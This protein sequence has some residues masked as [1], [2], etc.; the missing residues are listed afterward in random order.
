MKIAR[1]GLPHRYRFV[2]FFQRFRPLVNPLNPVAERVASH[3]TVRDGD[4]VAREQCVLLVQSLTNQSGKPVVV[5]I[6]QGQLADEMQNILRRRSIRHWMGSIGGVINDGAAA[7]G[8]TKVFLSKQAHILLESCLY[9]MHN[10]CRQKIASIVMRIIH[11]KRMIRTMRSINFIQRVM[12]G[13]LA[14]ARTRLLKRKKAYLAA[15]G[16]EDGVESPSKVDKYHITSL[17]SEVRELKRQDAMIQE[18]IKN[19]VAQ[20]KVSDEPDQKIRMDFPTTKQ[21][22][23]N[24]A[25]RFPSTSVINVKTIEASD[26]IGEGYQLLRPEK[27]IPLTAVSK[28]L[29]FGRNSAESRSSSVRAANKIVTKDHAMFKSLHKL[30]DRLRELFELSKLEKEVLDTRRRNRNKAAAAAAVQGGSGKQTPTAV[31]TDFGDLEVKMG[32]LD[33]IAKLTRTIYQYYHQYILEVRRSCARS[34]PKHCRCH[35]SFVFL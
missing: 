28:A 5:S 35:Q 12:R 29:S 15:L 27:L 13:A 25:A 10:L 6:I 2:E 17:E 32:T 4:Q 11:R 31:D 19:L 1:S 21:E 26:A 20:N 18:Q 8:L 3:V 24:F 33:K 14:R 7:V 22:L 34:P 30:M 16:S 23:M 9:H